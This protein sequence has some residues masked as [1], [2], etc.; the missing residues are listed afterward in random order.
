MMQLQRPEDYHPWS[1]Y[2]RA[3]DEARCMGDRRIGTEHLLIALLREPAVGGPLGLTPETARGA[4]AELDRAA[5]E[6]LGIPV[7]ARAAPVAPPERS[8]PARPP[9]REVLQRHMRL[10]PA[11]KRAL[12]ESSRELRRG[13][14]HPGPG[15]VMQALLE[16]RPP[17]PAAELLATLGV[18]VVSA[19]ESLRE[20]G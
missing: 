15:H 18:E 17:D 13:R 8:L 5:L 7:P 1:T 12:S 19:R 20:A 9:L 2:V 4:F 11:A 10:T 6:R 3:R 16:L 14:R